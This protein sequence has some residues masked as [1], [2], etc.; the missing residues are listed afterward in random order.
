MDLDTA[1]EALK[2]NTP[3]PLYPLAITFDDGYKN[4]REYVLPILDRHK[5][6]A[7]LF[8]V[9]NFIDLKQPLWVDRLE[10]GIGN[11]KKFAPLTHEEKK[12]LDARTR[13]HLKT[14][15]NDE[16]EATLG[17]MEQENGIALRNFEDTA[18]SVY[19]PLAWEDIDAM[20]DGPIRFGAHTKNHPILSRVTH[21]VARKEITGSCDALQTHVKHP[22]KVFAYPNG[23]RADFTDATEAIV[24]DAGC[25]GALTTIPGLN[26]VDSNFFALRRFS[27]DD[28]ESMISFTLRITGVHAFVQNVLKR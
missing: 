10:Y 27:M 9:T 11:G 6:V 23:R 5:A 4:A 18:S 13:E 12:R 20:Q 24:K 8:L 22:S 26:T 17:E 28:T 14:L 2:T 21:E 16:R 3:L 7:T 15:Q 1:L 25:I 19:A